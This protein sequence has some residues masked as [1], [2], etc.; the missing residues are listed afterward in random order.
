[1]TSQDKVVDISLSAEQLLPKYCYWVDKI[2]NNNK[3]DHKSIIKAISQL[4]TDD[5]SFKILQEET[6]EETSFPDDI[7][8]LNYSIDTLAQ[9]ST[10]LHT[11]STPILTEAEDS[12]HFEYPV[13]SIHKNSLQHL[14]ITANY[15]AK[16]KKTNNQWLISDL[17]LIIKNIESC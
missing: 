1:M 6:S 9:F 15:H 17:K 8:W 14:T 12:L 16:I 4:F 13:Q 10:N 7:A 3:G 5:I 11:L 2:N